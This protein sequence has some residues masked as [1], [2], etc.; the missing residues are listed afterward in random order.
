MNYNVFWTHCRG[1]SDCYVARGRVEM[2][3][4]KEVSGGCESVC[5]DTQIYEFEYSK[6]CRE[7]RN[8]VDH[9]RQRVQIMY[10]CWCM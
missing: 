5:I 9:T 6:K 2:M 8:L 7:P 4:G 3:V 1:G 10:N